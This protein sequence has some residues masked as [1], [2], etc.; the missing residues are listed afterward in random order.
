MLLCTSC[1]CARRF[2]SSSRPPAPSECVTCESFRALRAEVEHHA[3]AAPHI[4]QAV[5]GLL[6]T[7][8]E[9]LH[10]D[11]ALSEAVRGRA[12][13][14]SGRCD[15]QDRPMFSD[16]DAPPACARQRC[17]LPWPWSLR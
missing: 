2:R 11:K 10:V 3:G 5:V 16:L 14:R 4:E 8:S 7:A 9:L 12:M 1:G 15:A 17:A 6:A 13:P